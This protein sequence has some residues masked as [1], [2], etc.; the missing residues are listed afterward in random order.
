MA[1][2]PGDENRSTVRHSSIK[3]LTR[4]QLSAPV[5]GAVS[6]AVPASLTSGSSLIQRV[7]TRDI[8]LRHGVIVA[9]RVGMRFLRA[10]TKGT[11]DLGP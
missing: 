3:N 11:F 10:I 7:I 9:T 8:Q 1:R 2:A 5:R 6:Q 4:W